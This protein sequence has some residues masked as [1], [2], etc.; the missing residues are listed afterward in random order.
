MSGPEFEI[1]KAVTFEAAHYMPAEDKT[2]PYGRVHGHSFRLEA[3]LGGIADGERG[4]VEDLAAL[5]ARLN[6]LAETLDHGL[7]NEVEGLETPT[8]ENLC[9]WAAA[10]LSDAFPGK[11]RRVVLS[12]PSLNES[13]TLK[14][15]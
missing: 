6:R 9:A 4:W 5:G 11:V 3:V 8:L 10:Q 12:R 15:S 2:H 7:L 1:S 14:V 13:C